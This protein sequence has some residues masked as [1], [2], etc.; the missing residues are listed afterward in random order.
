MSEYNFIRFNKVGSKLGNYG[1]S[2]NSSYSFGI[3]S[4]LYSKEGIKN[5]KKAVLFFDKS[6]K[7]VAFSFTND[8]HA[9]GAFTVSHGTNNASLTARSFFIEND[10][11]QK[12]FF[13]KRIAKKEKDEKLGTLYIIDLLKKDER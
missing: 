1:I 8:E 12:K 11:N 13:G 6:R 5:F 4:G 3:L 2:I 7:A 10:L 9:E